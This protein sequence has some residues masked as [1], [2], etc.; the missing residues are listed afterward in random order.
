MG[1]LYRPADYRLCF[2][3]RRASLRLFWP[4][5]A[6]RPKLWADS[7]IIS[8]SLLCA[9]RPRPE[10]R[11]AGESTG[12]SISQA[13]YTPARAA[14][15]CEASSRPLGPPSPPATSALAR[16]ARHRVMR[17]QE[18]SGRPMLLPAGVSPCV[19]ES[20]PSVDR[21]EYLPTGVNAGPSIAL[22]SSLC[23]SLPL[24][25][26]LFHPL[27]LPPLWAACCACACVGVCLA[28]GAGTRAYECV[29]RVC[30][31]V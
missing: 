12:R 7:D 6:G 26:S 13:G 4:R 1:R 9:G 18:Y 25:A 30:F 20:G 27:R 19:S 14:G 17:H 28:S 15:G 31:M 5:P 10:Y 24:S 11:P 3:R 23:S 16:S 21:P 2:Q 22:L 29:W 8:G